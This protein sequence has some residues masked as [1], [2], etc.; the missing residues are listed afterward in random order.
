MK[1][2]IELIR[3]LIFL[4][5]YDGIPFKK[6]IFPFFRTVSIYFLDCQHALPPTAVSGKAILV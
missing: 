6:I 3:G 5:S 4:S 1:S 2:E